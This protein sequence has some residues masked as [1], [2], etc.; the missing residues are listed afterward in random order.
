M[1]YSIQGLQGCNLN[2][3]LGILG[4][5]GI[6]NATDD[7]LKDASALEE[8]IASCTKYADNIGKC[9]LLIDKYNQLTASEAYSNAQSIDSALDYASW[10]GWG[11]LMC[12][13]AGMAVSGR[14]SYYYQNEKQ[15]EK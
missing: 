2:R 13:V 1:E 4:T 9:S 15:G 5:A 3:F 6:G 8:E 11:L 12:G 10:A 7:P 14:K